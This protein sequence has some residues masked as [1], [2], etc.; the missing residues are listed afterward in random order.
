MS[1]EEKQPSTVREAIQRGLLANN[2]WTKQ[3]EDDLFWPVAY[4]MSRACNIAHQKGREDTL[5]H[6]RQAGVLPQAKSTETDAT[7]D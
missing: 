2:K 1:D 3:L 7:S 5:E 6:L 4:F